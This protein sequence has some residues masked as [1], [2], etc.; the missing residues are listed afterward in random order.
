MT[1]LVP[2]LYALSSLATVL[3]WALSLRRVEHRPIACLLS[4]YLAAD[5]ARHFLT[6]YAI[7]PAIKSF[8]DAPWTGW[9]RVAA[10]VDES[11]F[12]AGPLALVGTALVVYLGRKTWPALVA[13]LALVL[14]L[15]ITH[16][17]TLDESLPRFYTAV[18]VASVAIA[19][20]CGLTWYLRVKTPATSAQA[21]LSLAV[22]VE[23]LS[24]FFSWRVGVFTKWHLA[25]AIYLVLFGA[26]TLIQG[27]LVWQHSRSR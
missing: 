1:W 17:M 11:L 15:I 23:C 3:A 7:R 12:I 2:A 10:V 16:P 8:G 26:L 13:Y 5:V 9:A 18:Q 6:K 19:T 27:G 25:Q 14:Y 24:L 20:G 21:C 22:A 4:V